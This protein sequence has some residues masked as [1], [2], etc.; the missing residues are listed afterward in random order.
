MTIRKVTNRSSTITVNSAAVSDSDNTSTGAFD[1]PAG[2]TAQRPGSANS[3][4]TRFNSTT[5][6]LEFYDGTAWISTN[7]IP[8]ITSIT[9]NINDAYATNLVFAIANNTDNVDIIF[10]EGGAALHTAA[11]VAVSSGSFTLA[12]PASVYGQTAGDVIQISIKNQDGTPSSNTITKTVQAAPSGGT[13]TTSGNFRIHTFNSSGT[14]N[15]GGLNITNAEYLVI[16]GGAGG[17]SDLGGGGGAGGYRTS[18]VGQSSGGGGSAES[19]VALSGSYTVTV[20]AGGAGGTQT[21][22]NTDPT[23][24]QNG[25]DSVFGSITS[26]AGGGGGVYGAVSSARKDGKNGGSGGGGGG[27]DP[28]DRGQGGSGTTNQGYGGG[29]SSNGS[30]YTSGGGGGA[31][32]A[33]QDADAAGSTVGGAGGNG[34][35]SNIPGSA[36]T[37]AGGGGGSG[38][39]TGSG[40]TG[41]AGGSGGGGAGGANMGTGSANRGVDASPANSGSGGGGGSWS[42]STPFIGGAGASGVVIVRYDMTA[43]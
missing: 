16:A 28:G 36:V 9:G 39:N 15:A 40:G 31:A 34:V 35:S 11:G 27:G 20:G 18:V 26:I 37:R 17:G 3:G 41:G 21:T 5:G 23:T 13:I 19:R 25:S 4:M 24:G 14:F 32:A 1:M 2:T 22:R 30:P 7:L 43:N 12:V 10:S 33:G 42:G 29:I 6:S 8:T 38:Y